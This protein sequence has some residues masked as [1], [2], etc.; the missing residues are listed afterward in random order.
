MFVRTLAGA[1]LSALLLFG[2]DGGGTTP[3]MDGG[4]PGSDGGGGGGRFGDPPPTPVSDALTTDSRG[5]VLAITDRES[6]AYGTTVHLRPGARMSEIAL[7]VR[8]I[9]IP[10]PNRTVLAGPVIEIAPR[11]Q[12]ITAIDADALDRAEVVMPVY[13]GPGANVRVAR[14]HEVREEW[15]VLPMGQLTWADPIAEVFP[16]IT[17]RI[18][19]GGIY[20]PVL[21]VYPQTSVVSEVHGDDYAVE[22]VASRSMT[23]A[24]RG[25]PFRTAAPGE[26]RMTSD[27]LRS[28]V[29]L[30]LPDGEYLLRIAG[31]AGEDPRCVVVTVPIGRVLTIGDTAPPCDGLPE[32]AMEVST[33][34]ARIGEPVT[35]T[36]RATSAS[37]EPLDW[38]LNRTGGAFDV[39]SGT[40]TSGGT[41]TAE[42]TGTR[43]GDFEITFTAYDA[44]GRFD[45]ARIPVRVRGNEPPEIT[46]FLATPV[47]LETG[48][49]EGSRGSLP[50]MSGPDPA[51]GLSLLTV[52]A[53]DPDGDPISYFW[54]HGLPGNYYDAATGT[55]LGR[56]WPDGLVTDPATELPYTGDSVLYMA[57]PES[58]LCDSMTSPLGYWLGLHVTASDGEGFDRSWAMVGAECLEPEPGA[59]GFLRCIYQSSDGTDACYHI[60]AAAPGARNGETDC[61]PV[62]GD[63]GIGRCPA[64]G[65][66]C[67]WDN[68]GF[69]TAQVFYDSRDYESGMRA[70]VGGTWTTAWG[71]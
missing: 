5:G 51:M 18:V 8:A 19:E 41:V 44:M 10:Q 36:A 28:L 54:Y 69:E 12:L 61:L 37:G 45:E 48:L 42:W 40:A 52:E 3:G 43:V 31:L 26:V 9:E 7:T 68:D 21:A 14:Y 60:D 4:T 55:Q 6:P 25:F 53:T 38:Y 22:V 2:C 17:F 59:E 49:P 63:W 71:G 39:A 29:P 33:Q 16:S 13:E 67:V 47:Q 57:A 64:G 50:P 66:G 20:A 35:I 34:L 58:F 1:A 62:G 56:G 30:E 32:A 24:A 11:D 65:A 46:S 27:P 70:C 23:E 15:V